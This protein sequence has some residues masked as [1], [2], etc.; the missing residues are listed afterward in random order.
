MWAVLTPEKHEQRLVTGGPFKFV[1]HPAYLGYI[2]AALGNLLVGGKFYLAGVLLFLVT[3]MP[4]VIYLE[5][6]EMNERL[7]TTK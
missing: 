2:L 4:L 5:E 1:P 7:K 6:R 3:L